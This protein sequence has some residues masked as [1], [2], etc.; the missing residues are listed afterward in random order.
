MITDR[1]P[2]LKGLILD[3]DGV[4]WKDVEPIVDLPSVFGRIEGLGLKVVLATNNATKRIEEYLEKFYRFGV[5]LSPTQIITSAE[6]AADYL[7]EFANSDKPVYV[8]GTDSLKHVVRSAGFVVAD[9]ADYQTSGAVIVGMDTEINFRKL[10]NATLLIRNGALF[11]ATNPDVTFPTPLGQIPGAGAIV[12]AIQVASQKEPV[13]IGKPYPAMFQKA[14]SIM[15]LDPLEV[16]G[17]GD[18]LETDIYGAQRASC[19]SG[20][21][22]SGVSTKEMAEAWQPSIDIIAEDLL[23]L[24]ND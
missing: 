24:L 15:N 3:M 10:T 16:M 12:S 18:R 20:C 22:L 2:S 17:V 23:R 14:F 7:R 4:L 13:T 1:F 9:E 5:E 6:V 19:L 21:V 11:V 8:V